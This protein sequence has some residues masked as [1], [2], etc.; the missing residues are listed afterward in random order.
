MRKVLSGLLAVGVMVA[1]IGC[2]VKIPPKLQVRD[3]SSGKSYETYQPWGEV[4][5]GAGYQF[6]DIDSGKRITLTN[7]E[8]STIEGAKKV[9]DKSPEA[10]AFKEAK[11]RGGVKD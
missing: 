2:S 3:V 5:K 6:T 4:I 8:V 7:Y 9:P 10:T 11:V 1:V